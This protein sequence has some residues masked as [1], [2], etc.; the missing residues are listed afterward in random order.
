VTR[1]VEVTAFPG[2]WGGSWVSLFGVLEMASPQ[3]LKKSSQHRSLSESERSGI[4]LKYLRDSMSNDIPSRKGAR[5]VG[6]CLEVL[7]DRSE[8]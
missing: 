5:E 3:D 6:H 1:S 2:L 4:V 7:D 8:H